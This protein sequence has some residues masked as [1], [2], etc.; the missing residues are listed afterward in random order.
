M[1]VKPHDNNNISYI[2]GKFLYVYLF[3]E[4]NFLCKYTKKEN[5]L[6]QLACQRFCIISVQKFYAWIKMFS[7]AF[8]DVK[9]HFKHFLFHGISRRTLEFLGYFMCWCRVLNS[10]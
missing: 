4:N 10:N 5:N 6:W 3:L 2:T 1:V 8:P 7:T 9:L